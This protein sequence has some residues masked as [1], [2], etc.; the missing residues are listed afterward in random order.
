M[1]RG[2]YAARTAAG[3]ALSSGECEV[4]ADEKAITLSPP[5][6]A[7]LRFPYEQV[8]GLRG[9]DYRIEITLDDGTAIELSRLGAMFGDL[10]RL[11]LDGRNEV[12][13]RGLFLRG[14]KP[15]DAFPCEIVLAS[16]PCPAELR[17]Y[18]DRFSVL[19]ERGDP[20][21]FPYAFVQGAALDEGTYQ[22]TVALSAGESLVVG[23]LKRRTTELVGLLNDR[24]AASRKRTAAA[25][26]EYLPGL[27][28]LELQALARLLADGVAARREEIE[29]INGTIW[30]QLEKVVAGTAELA[31]TY[32]FLAA[33]SSGPDM[34]LGLK[35]ARPADSET[36]KG[37]ESQARA[38]G[39]VGS[40]MESGEGAQQEAEAVVAEEP[41]GRQS[42]LV[43]WFF[44]PVPAGGL[45]KSDFIA[46]EITSEPDHAT[47]FFRVKAGGDWKGALERLN[48]A[49]LALDF[50]RR[51]IFQSEDEL[52]RDPHWFAMRHLPY[53][54]AL[55]ESFA[56]RAI[57]T[58]PEAWKTSVERI[59]SGGSAA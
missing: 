30:S 33:K 22:V 39:D 47:Y 5:G 36:K 52:G 48:R 41:A 6:D 53:L 29:A 13:E 18:E 38:T 58:S 24:L 25:L 17:L 26:A 11:M 57:H 31:E 8:V 10:L 20:F 43:T 9:Q 12:W 23:K 15:L 4:E 49:M 54:R 42:S 51:P 45:A 37:G 50:R 19:P 46:Q 2:H 55:R 21:G 28:A 14:V 3:E 44:C 27:P 59:L 32:T 40:E 7:P 56:G 35:Q 16:G 34:A 1:A